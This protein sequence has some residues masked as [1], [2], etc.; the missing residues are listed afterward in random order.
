MS[1]APAPSEAPLTPG[2]ATASVWMGL[3]GMVLYAYALH[4]AFSSTR[5]GAGTDLP[6]VLAATGCAL[7]MAAVLVAWRMRLSTLLMLAAGSGALTWLVTL[8]QESPAW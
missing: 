3:A 5:Q 7:F 2:R 6:P 8:A 4:L 1:E